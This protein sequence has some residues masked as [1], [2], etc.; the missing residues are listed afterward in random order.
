MHLREHVYALVATIPRGR[1]T[2]YG[3]IGKAL[4]TRGYRA[5]GQILHRNPHWPDV[6][7]HRVVAQNGSLASHYGIGGP[8]H[9]EKLL[10]EEGVL[11]ENGRVCMERH[12]FHFSSIAEK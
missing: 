12:V 4:G 9:Q 10:R 2:T 7:C 6:P 5:I 8:Q 1:V 11:I 3:A